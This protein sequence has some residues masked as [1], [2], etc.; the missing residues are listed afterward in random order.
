LKNT[1]IADIKAK[2]NW[3]FL[4]NVSSLQAQKAPF[5]LLAFCIPVASS[6]TGQSSNFSL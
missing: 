6:K 2:I 3:S 1:G 5:F 4:V